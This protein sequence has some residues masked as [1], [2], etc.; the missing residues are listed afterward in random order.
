MQRDALLA[1][2]DE[3]A[4]YHEDRSYHFMKGRQMEDSEYHRGACRAL[5]ELKLEITKPVEDFR[6]VVLDDFRGQ[7]STPSVEE[8]ALG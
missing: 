6:V 5:R 8:H 7:T 3:T 4:K 2:I 1:L